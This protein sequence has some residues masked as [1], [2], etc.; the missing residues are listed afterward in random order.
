MGSSALAMLAMLIAL[1]SREARARRSPSDQRSRAVERNGKLLVVALCRERRGQRQ[2]CGG[3]HGRGRRHVAAL[4]RGQARQLLERAQLVAEGVA[5]V[6]CAFP[7][8]AGKALRLGPNAFLLDLQVC[9]GAGRARL[10]FLRRIA[11]AAGHCSQVMRDLLRYAG[12]LRSHVFERARGLG[13]G[14]AAQT[15]EFRSSGL[16]VGGGALRQLLRDSARPALRF[17]DG[18]F[19]S[20]RVAAHDFVDLVGLARKP[21]Q[22]VGKFDVALLQRGIDAHVGGLERARGMH[23]GLALVVEPVGHA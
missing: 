23:D 9:G 3:R 18:A 8:D 11:E 16:R 10:Q 5:H 12:N 1:S 13:V 6:L 19:Q 7:R 2:G 15:L 21:L 14:L 17:S 4:A 20:L 22:R